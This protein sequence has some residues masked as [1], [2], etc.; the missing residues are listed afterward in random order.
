MYSRRE[1]W[2]GRM[3]MDIKPSEARVL[4]CVKRAT[5][6]D[7]SDIKVSEISRLLQVTS[8][9]V[10]QILKSLEAQQLIERHLDP[11]DRRSVGITLTKKGAEITDQAT[12]AFITSIQ[13]LVKFLG[14][15]DSNQLA[16]LLLKVSR[17]YSERA[18][19]TTQTFWSTDTDL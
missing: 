14:E 6:A 16:E 4:M 12:K 13:N 2:H 7:S 9:T 17:Y 19:E 11:A 5:C 1:G 8:P 15:E 3:G 10:T 18:N